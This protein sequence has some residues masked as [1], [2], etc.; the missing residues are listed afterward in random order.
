MAGGKKIKKEVECLLTPEELAALGI[1][2][3]EE[4]DQA[5]IYKE[6]AT[7]LDKSAKEKERQVAEKKVKRMVECIESKDFV[8]F[9]V[10]ITRT[11]DEKYW[12]GGTAVVGEPRPM[13]GEERQNTMFESEDQNDADKPTKTT[14]KAPKGRG[15]GKSAAN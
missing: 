10:C 4:R 9:E 15:R 11:D 2:A 6:K 13:T 12:P 1:K 5:R 3:C 8:R 7:E 14:I